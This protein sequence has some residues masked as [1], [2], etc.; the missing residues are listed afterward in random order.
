[1]KQINDFTDLQKESVQEDIGYKRQYI[2][3]STEVM[4][5]LKKPSPPESPL[6][7]AW[8]AEQERKKNAN[9]V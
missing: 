2:P 9:K 5:E 8:L 3:W 7:L 4:R 1:M 6:K